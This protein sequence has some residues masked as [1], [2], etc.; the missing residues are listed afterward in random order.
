MQR[1]Q[2]NISAK[3]LWTFLGYAAHYPA[4]VGFKYTSQIN[5]K[6]VTTITKSSTSYPSAF[7]LLS[8]FTTNHYMNKTQ[9][10]H[11]ESLQTENHL[12]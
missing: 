11:N 6:A 1:L 10:A 7:K 4:K 8:T 12:I 3:H 5:T 9:Y 2:T